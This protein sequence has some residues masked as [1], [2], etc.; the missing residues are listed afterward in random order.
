MIKLTLIVILLSVQFYA[1]SQVTGLV[2][3]NET[4]N[5]VPG[6]TIFFRTLNEG[7][8]TDT[9]GL[10][11]T[12][13]RGEIEISAVGY[14]TKSTKIDEDSL[15]Y[16]FLLEKGH[17]YLEEVIVEAFARS[18]RI[19]DVPGS[20]S[21]IQAERIERENPVT[22]VPVINQAPGV[23][24]HSG[25]LNTSRITIRG[26][27]A[28]VPYATGKVRAYLNNIPLTNGSGISII[29][30]IDPSIMERIEIIK[31]PATSVYGAGL[32]GTI[33]IT[34]KK[35]TS[36]PAGLSNSFE[37][38]SY[39][40]YNNTFN[41]NTGGEHLGLSIRYNH[42]Q[43]EGYRENNQYN[44]D[45]ITIISNASPRSNTDVT[46][47][48]AYTSLKAHIPSSI[49]STTYIDSPRSAAQNWQR[50][51][52]FE[53]YDKLLS[54]ISA[55]YDFSS[56]LSANLSIFTTI[57]N[58]NEMRPFDVLYEDRFSGGTRF[59]LTYS[60][61]LPAGSWQVIG[62]GELFSENF[63]YS[64]YQNIGGLGEQ[65]N[66]I[67][68]HKE[69]ISWY[70]AFTQAD[71]D[72]QRLKISAG[73]NMNANKIDYFDL[74]NKGTQTPEG[75]YSYGRIFSPRLSANYRYFKSNS[76]FMTVSH[77]F[78]P[79][80]LAETLSPDG[81]INPDILP[82]TSWNIEGGMRGNL[83]DHSI[84]YDINLYNMR[85]TD[86]LVA[87]R[88]SEDAWVGKNAGESLHR[89]LEVE[90]QFIIFRDNTESQKSWWG[91]EKLTF[92]PNLTVNDFRFTDFVDEGVDYSGKYLPGIPERVI[93][94]EIYGKL[95]GG[96]Y[97][98]VNFRFVGQMPMNDQNSLFSEP[99]RIA[100]AVAGFKRKLTGNLHFNTWVTAGN[101]LGEKYAS[102]ILVNA[103]SF[104][105]RPPR[106]YYPGNP[107]NFSA[108]IKISYQFN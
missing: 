65:G 76:F 83:F 106:Y 97:A 47:L 29:E 16:T 71:L 85:V 107:L 68:D 13:Y 86:L 42:V 105:N 49:D 9:S 102:M 96:L 54:G 67:S 62:G 78:S 19:V 2:I 72:L 98:S 25:A 108:G 55:R 6:A 21:L 27:G 93:N 58:E 26:I 8:I 61:T 14:K 17:Y 103:P 41:F 18:R 39:D 94:S 11:R 28:R 56:S 40:L 89:G 50:T 7:A 75:I 77:G 48:L 99:Y 22:V 24:A 5:P 30:D 37:A 4:G 73:L 87:E 35:P 43:S 31:G 34:A 92:S 91:P 46:F 104:N 57:N 20:L 70:N 33:V 95:V 52:G 100:S 60:G 101:F 81:S 45:G 38:G 82:E 90:L 3:D 44:R 36:Q 64:S 74:L 51:N 79:P 1:A 59:K 88:V 63:K 32:G 80:S 69:Q 66:M 12:G 53:D 15:Y 23:Y 10:F 84:F